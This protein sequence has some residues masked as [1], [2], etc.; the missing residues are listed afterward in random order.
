[1]APLSSPSA[2]IKS[3]GAK[4][5]VQLPLYD[6]RRTLRGE[7]RRILLAGF[8]SGRLKVRATVLMG[9]SGDS[10]D[11]TLLNETRRCVRDALSKLLPRLA[12]LP[13]LA[14]CGAA[15]GAKGMAGE[16]GNDGRRL[17]LEKSPESTTCDDR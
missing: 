10:T 14:S 7:S 4:S 17:G 2:T 12:V 16:R 3:T 1:M 5:C 8:S 15:A 9:S 6:A 13:S 11:M